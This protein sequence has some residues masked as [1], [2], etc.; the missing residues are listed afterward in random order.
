[1]AKWPRL[2][3]PPRSHCQRQR[4]PTEKVP[5]ELNG[6][7]LKTLLCK[8]LCEQFLEAFTTP[9][10]EAKMPWDSPMQTFVPLRGLYLPRGSES[11]RQG[12][13]G[14]VGSDRASR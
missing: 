1:M 2:P 7:L 14:R 4:P 6:L 3:P 5:G 13:A 8:A 9:G 12:G 10:P 11:T